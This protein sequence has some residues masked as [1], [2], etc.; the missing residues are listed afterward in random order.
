MPRT[1]NS[2]SRKSPPSCMVCKALDSAM[3]KELQQLSK[4]MELKISGKK[5]ELVRRIKYYCACHYSNKT[6]RFNP[7]I[8]TPARIEKSSCL[9]QWWDEKSGVVACKH[10][11]LMPAPVLNLDLPIDPQ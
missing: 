6:R 8:A 2:T 10:V 4:N 9:Q 7:T 3:L 5:S 1:V 11:D